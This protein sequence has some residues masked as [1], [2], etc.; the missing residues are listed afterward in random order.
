M[1]RDGGTF[2]KN[3]P[4]G[5]R[6]LTLAPSIFTIG[7]SKITTLSATRIIRQYQEDHILYIFLIIAKSGTRDVIAEQVR[8]LSLIT[9]LVVHLG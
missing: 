2:P 1:V 4:V 6:S 8:L 5:C 7:R 9:T 3:L